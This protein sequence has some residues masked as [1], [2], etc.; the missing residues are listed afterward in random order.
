MPDL[1]G[2]VALI[3]QVCST[4][5]FIM[6]IIWRLSF[7]CFSLLQTLSLSIPSSYAPSQ[8]GLMNVSHCK[9]DISF[10]GIGH[11]MGNLLAL[12]E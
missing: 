9:H 11:I 6:P 4:V 8:N 7:S 1:H 2:V 10:T 3:L 12:L 5:Y